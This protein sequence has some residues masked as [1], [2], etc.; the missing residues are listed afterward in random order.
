MNIKQA[1][2]VYRAQIPQLNRL[3]T[4]QFTLKKDIYA[5]IADYEELCERVTKYINTG[6]Y[7]EA[8]EN[9]VKM[10]ELTQSIEVLEARLNDNETEYKALETALREALQV[11][12]KDTEDTRDAYYQQ[13]QAALKLHAQLFAMV[14]D[15]N[16]KRLKILN[17]RDIVS[18]IT[19][20]I[21]SRDEVSLPEPLDVLLNEL[22]L[23]PNKV[24]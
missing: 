14:G 24:G 22:S 15:L 17:R 3:K 19:K 9:E 21:G 6:R 18:R 11:I 20:T 10:N 8:E 23:N 12:M 7:S 16:E 2:E 5:L 13:K 4:E 1:I